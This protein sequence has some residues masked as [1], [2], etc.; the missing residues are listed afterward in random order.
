MAKASTES[1]AKDEENGDAKP[2]M[3]KFQNLTR[4]LIKVSREELAEAEKHKNKKSS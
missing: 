4:R 2:S 1:H 3:A